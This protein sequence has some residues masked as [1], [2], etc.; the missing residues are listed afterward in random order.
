MEE[1]LQGDKALTGNSVTAPCVSGNHILVFRNNLGAARGYVNNKI[2]PDQ[3]GGNDA[4]AV[5][6]S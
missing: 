3:A 1:K 2:L 4:D 5:L 6:S